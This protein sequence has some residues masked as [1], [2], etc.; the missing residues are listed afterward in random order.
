MKKTKVDPSLKKHLQ[1]ALVVGTKAAHEAG[2]FLSKKYGKFTTLNE[3]ADTTLVTEADRG[4]E[5]IVIDII[6]KSFPQDEIIGEESGFTAGKNPNSSFRWHIDPLDG[7][8]NFVHSFPMFCVSI[9]LEFERNTF[10]LGIIYNPISKDFYKGALG[11]GAFKNGKPIHVSNCKKISDAMLTTG[12]SYRR[13][14]FYEKELLTFGRVLRESRAIRR[15]GSAALDLA[16]VASGQFDGFWE[17]GLASWD[18]AAGIAILQEAGGKVTKLDG[19]PYQFGG[20]SILA[21]NGLLHKP[22]MKLMNT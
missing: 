13:D 19:S 16:I 15:V 21:T 22:F 11:T 10:A 9:G 17:R 7:T 20:E 3:K 18:V 4:A 6:Q 14:L 8:T 12:F 5:K 1:K 2:K